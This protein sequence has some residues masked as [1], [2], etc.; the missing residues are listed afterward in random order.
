[1]TAAQENLV[2]EETD[3]SAYPDF[4]AFPARLDTPT[5]EDG[6]A[7]WRIARDSQALNVNYSAPK[8]TE[9]GS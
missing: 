1:M 2:R 6:A 4:P 7:I 9:L 8:G 5:V 3:S